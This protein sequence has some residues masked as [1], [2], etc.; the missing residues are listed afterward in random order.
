MQPQSTLAA[1]HLRSGAA[2]GCLAGLWCMQSSAAMGPQQGVING[3]AR[4]H[5]VD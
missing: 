2:V 1:R 4:A 3:K 5:R